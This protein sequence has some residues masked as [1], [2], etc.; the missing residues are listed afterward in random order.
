MQIPFAGAMPK[1][2]DGHGCLAVDIFV[3]THFGSRFKMPS[4]LAPARAVIDMPPPTTGR[5]A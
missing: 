4:V 1:G 2:N 5:L 3:A